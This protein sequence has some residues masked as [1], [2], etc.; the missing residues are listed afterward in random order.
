MSS[1]LP[2]AQMPIPLPATVDI[3]TC[4]QLKDCLVE[5]LNSRSGLMLDAGAFQSG[6]IT[7]VQVLLSAAK[8]AERLGVSME[9]ANVGPAFVALL[10]RC[11]VDADALRLRSREQ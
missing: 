3:R 2:K 10:N 8:T 6:D 11:G 1:L 5:C 7:F 4:G 9:I